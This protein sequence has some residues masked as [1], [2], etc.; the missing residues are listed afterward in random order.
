MNRKKIR[1][2]EKNPIEI[3]EEAFHLLRLSPISSIGC[4]YIGSLPF[5]LGVLYFWADMSKGAYAYKHCSEG[6]LF[7]SILFI[8]MKCWQSVFTHRLK[9][10]ISG[11]AP[12]PVT[13]KNIMHLITTQTI[14]QPSGMFI[15]PAATIFAFPFCWVY[16]FYQNVSVYG[17]DNTKETKSIIKSSWEQAALWPKQNHILIWILC[18]FLF[19]FVGF[20]VIVFIPVIGALSMQLSQVMAYIWGGIFTLLIMILSPLSLIVAVNLGIT[21]AIIP[22]LIRIFFGTETVFTLSNIHVVNTTFFACI[23]GG[24]Y[25]C[26]DPVM[27]TCYVLRC[28]YGESVK[29]GADLKVKLREFSS[30]RKKMLITT[31]L[32]LVI[33]LPQIS[34][35]DESKPVYNS[36]TAP[37]YVSSEQ[38]DQSINDVMKKNKYTWRI[39]REKPSKQDDEK[40]GF[41]ESF[42]R[43]VMKTITK[44]MKATARGIGKFFEWLVK[45]LS[46]EMKPLSH[47]PGINWIKSVQF[48]TYIL[49][50]VIVS[51]LVIMIIRIWM[52]RRRSLK[53]IKSEPV[54]GMPDLEDEETQADELP[55][56]GW[57]EMAGELF[58]KGDLRL[59]LRAYFLAILAFLAKQ[60]LISIA[61]YKSNLD[62]KKEL[63]LHENELSDL[64]KMF[65][66]NLSIFERIWYGMHEI[67]TDIVDQFR[68]NYK[69]IITGVSK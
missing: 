7:V 10:Q 50:V 28:F 25:L 22:E 62:Y 29:T 15:I 26:L 46:P 36:E 5:I 55:V 49:L 66:Q 16:A 3:V 2:Q 34:S 47:K 4:Y 11:T 57:L 38:L 30:K 64:M 21:I 41:L 19:L 33:F 40:M 13:I 1:L 53:E 6:A 20:L 14:I 9:M 44:W 31:I 39:P 17:F 60:E 65:S 43:N 69:G 61:K 24:T 37:K 23:Y 51:I 59:G 12:A 68:N 54:Y 48:L 56:D 18:P 42:T 58:E 45:K 27:K 52:Q 35:A 8:W 63:Q 67:T 32:L